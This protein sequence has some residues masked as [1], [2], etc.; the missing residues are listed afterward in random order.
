MDAAIA[1]AGAA[2]AAACDAASPGLLM[3]SGCFASFFLDPSYLLIARSYGK[4]TRQ[5]CLTFFFFLFS[6]LHVPARQII[7]TRVPNQCI[8]KVAEGIF[9][10][11]G[12]KEF[13]INCGVI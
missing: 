12:E 5:I 11:I 6:L 2:V 3:A 9:Q 7:K 1:A 13:V 10:M 8:A 4:L